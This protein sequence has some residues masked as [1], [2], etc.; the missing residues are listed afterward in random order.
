[1]LYLWYT[2][3]QETHQRKITIS[4]ETGHTDDKVD[5]RKVTYEVLTN[6]HKEL[7]FLSHLFPTARY[8]GVRLSENGTVEGLT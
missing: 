5:T 1:M 6:D 2:N 4:N 3:K 7:S 8:V